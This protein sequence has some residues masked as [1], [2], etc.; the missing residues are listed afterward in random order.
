M[1]FT[2]LGASGFIGS[3]LVSHLMGLEGVECSTPSKNDPVIFEEDL[4]NVIYSIG[5]TADFRERPFDTV[6]AHVCR[7]V[8]VLEKA[9]FNSLLYLSSTRVYG[10][11]SDGCEESIL[12]V[13]PQSTNDL[14]NLSKLMG[15]SLC[16]SSR[17]P[18]VRIARLSNV[19]GYDDSSQNFLSTIIK[20]A[21]ERKEI[22]LRIGLL[23]EK[24]YIEIDDVVR[25]LPQIAASGQY[26]IYNVASGINVSNKQLIDRLQRLTACSV[27][28]V[29]VAPD[30]I[31][32]K[33]NIER[34]Q[35]EFDFR[36]SSVLD[37][38]NDLV[39]RYRRETTS[40]D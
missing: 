17:H 40:N 31:F 4:G 11:I 34:I 26:N 7:L 29:G 6:R 2:V 28:V 25:I 39:N 30:I 16:L 37:S 19:C 9:N 32:P 22:E 1:R 33:I 12:K 14:Y 13:D 18:D 23:S 15:E 35:N 5:L 36:P 10:R 24:D 27:Q 8:D 3:H 20:D 21:V 38:L